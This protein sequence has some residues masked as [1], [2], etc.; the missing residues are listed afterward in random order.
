MN[1]ETKEEDFEQEFYPRTGQFAIVDASVLEELEHDLVKEAIF[2]P[3]KHDSAVFKVTADYDDTILQRLTIEPAVQDD[4]SVIDQEFE[5]SSEVGKDRD[6]AG[7][8]EGTRDGIRKP[9]PGRNADKPR[10]GGSKARR[11]RKFDP[12]KKRPVSATSNDNS[13]RRRLRRKTGITSNEEIFRFLVDRMGEKVTP[14]EIRQIEDKR[15]LEET[16]NLM[17]SMSSTLWE[18]KD[19]KIT[20]GRFFLPAEHY[21]LKEGL[22]QGLPFDDDWLYETRQLINLVKRE[23]ALA[24]AEWLTD[25]RERRT[26]KD[27]S[28]P[29][30]STSE[31]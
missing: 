2:V 8:H 24:L 23:E 26:K 30:A 25:G 12:R 5:V 6:P 11:K 22:I 18:E 31:S 29:A 9:D 21:E 20:N 27:A 17:F 4:G 14:D 16:V 7:V 28:R 3:V 10:T 19:G 1:K 15:E 13:M